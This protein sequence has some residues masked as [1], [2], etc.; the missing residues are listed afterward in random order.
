MV[1]LVAAVMASRSEHEPP[2]PDASLV[3]LTVIAEA[4][5][6]NARQARLT[7]MNGTRQR[8]TGLPFTSLNPRRP[9]LQTCVRN[10]TG[11][12]RRPSPEAVDEPP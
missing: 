3:V 7:I 4:A 6:L 2:D 11:F 10:N 1:L 9:S 5:E 12:S 8:F